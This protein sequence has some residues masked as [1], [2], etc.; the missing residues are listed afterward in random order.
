MCLNLHTHTHTPHSLPCD[1]TANLAAVSD[2]GDLLEVGDVL[3]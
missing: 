1:T 2:P 3:Y